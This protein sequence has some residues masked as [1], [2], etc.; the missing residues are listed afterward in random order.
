MESSEKNFDLRETKEPSTSKMIMFSMGYFFNTFL[1]I[2]FNNFV[3]TFYEGELGMISFVALWPIYLALANVI[4]TLWSMIINPIFGFLTDKPLKWTK[5]RGF[6][7]PWFIIGGIPTI[8][9]FF[10]LF[11]PPDVIGAESLFPILIYYLII[12]F[13]YEIFY[14]LFQT[15]S[16]GAFAAHFRGDRTR[17][18]AGLLTQIFVFVANFLVITIWSQIIDPGI[19][20][21]FTIAAFISIILLTI[22]LIIFIPG[23]KESDEIKN[24][25][26]VGY[27]TADRVSFFGTMKMAFKQKNF[28]LAILSYFFFMIAMG[29]MN[30]NAV[31]FVDDV[32]QEEQYIRSIGSILMLISSF[33]IMPIWIRVAKKIG[34]SNTYTIGLFFFGFSLLLSTF[35]TNEIEF[36]IT[37]TLSGISSAMYMIMLSPV[38]A[39]CYDEI[40][41]KTKK[42]HEATLI[43]IRN[44]FVRISISVQSFIVAII[45]AITF[46]NPNDLSHSTDALVGL[47]II[48]GVFPFIFCAIG[49]IIFYKWFDL[50]GKKKKEMMKKLQDMGL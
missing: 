10:L 7:S 5:K 36:Y 16:F 29:L 48:G 35:I 47:R 25:F 38:L 49:A 28:M 41:V 40:A 26:I 46:Y 19:P 33:L 15:H 32:L 43:G 18:K 30:M 24:R 11:T 12:V 39:D 4:Y 34:H 20:I 13:L 44:F 22:S 9:L 1:I 2:A 37:S 14:S 45:H 42:H 23:S 21:S 17:R 8:I 6:H 50:K 27:E 3:W 31:N